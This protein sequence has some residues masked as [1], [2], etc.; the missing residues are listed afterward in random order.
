MQEL[1]R[2]PSAILNIHDSGQ[3]GLNRII[4]QQV[5]QTTPSQTLSMVDLNR[6]T[7]RTEEVSMIKLLSIRKNVDLKWV[8]AQR[9]FNQ[10][11]YQLSYNSIRKILDEDNYYTQGIP[12]FCS[13][14]VELKKVGELYSIAHKLVSADPDK[15]ISWFSVVSNPKDHRLILAL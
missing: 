7:G 10:K 6:N 4:P 8:E 2:R 9:F 13:V 11:L 3:E 12:L 15:A 1:R 14:L 5:A